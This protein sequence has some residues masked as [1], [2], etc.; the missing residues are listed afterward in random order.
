MLLAEECEMQCCVGLPVLSHGGECLP[1]VKR[2]PIAWEFLK[3]NADLP[4]S[5]LPWS[6]DYSILWVGVPCLVCFTF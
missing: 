1:R 4:I 6:T 3:E 5:S 2:S